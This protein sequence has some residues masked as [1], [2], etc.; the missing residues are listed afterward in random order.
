MS[1][2][3]SGVGSWVSETWPRWEGVRG[4]ASGKGPSPRA[5]PISRVLEGGA[6]FQRATLGGRARHPGQGRP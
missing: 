4:Y 2:L 3:W 1:C 5:L 6:A